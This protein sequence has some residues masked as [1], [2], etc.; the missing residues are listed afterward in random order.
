MRESLASGQPRDDY[1]EFLQLVL[2]FFREATVAN[3]PLRKPGA[4]HHARWM[5]KAIYALKL[6]LLQ[7]Q[8]KMTRQELKGVT[9]ICMFVALVYAKAWC[10]ATRAEQAPRVDLEFLHDLETMLE[11]TV[12]T[13]V[14]K[15]AQAAMKRHLWYFSETLV[16]LA[17]FDQGVLQEEKQRMRENLAK[18][19][20]SKVLKR[21]EGKIILG[22]FRE[23]KLSEFVT[24][25]TN[26]LFTALG[27]NDTFVHN[28]ASSWESDPHYKAGLARV[29]VLAVVNDSAER[30]VALMEKFNTALTTKE[31]EKQFSRTERICLRSGRVNL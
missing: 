21:L 2:I 11:A 30:G 7:G 5:A 23:K 20:S 12:I 14:T 29:H 15:Q 27:I 25:R 19:P 1:K 3:M 16:A 28:P 24:S 22:S 26:D 13:D 18:L 8:L 17:F 9:E 31:E 10:R 6:Y 4:Y